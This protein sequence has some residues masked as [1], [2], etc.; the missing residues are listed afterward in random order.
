MNIRYQRCETPPV[1]D[2]KEELLNLPVD[3]I[4]FLIFDDVEML[5]PN[6]LPRVCLSV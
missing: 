1:P 2:Q 6:N 5:V 3:G 4:G